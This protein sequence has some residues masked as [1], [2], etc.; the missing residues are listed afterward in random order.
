MISKAK[1]ITFKSE[2]LKV[3]NKKTNFIDSLP[4][5]EDKL[6][7]I[8][9]NIN[10]S[11]DFYKHL[12]NSFNY[13]KKFL[14][15]TNYTS[16]EISALSY[17]GVPPIEINQIGCF[18]SRLIGEFY[19]YDPSASIE[20]DDDFIMANNEQ[21]IKYLENHA[22]YDLNSNYTK[23]QMYDGYRNLLIGMCCF[24]IFTEYK[25]N[26]SVDHIIKFENKD[27]TMVGFDPSAKE[28]NKQDGKFCFEKFIY[29]EDEFKEEFPDIDF[30]EI[31]NASL[32]NDYSWNFY[33]NSKKYVTVYDYYEKEKKK[34]VLYYLKNGRSMKKNDYLKMME[35]RSVFRRLELDDGNTVIDKKVYFE[36][37]INRYRIV[38]DRIISFEKTD[39]KNLPYVFIGRSEKIKDNQNS[40]VR[41]IIVPY[42]KNAIGAQ[43]LINYSA[44][45]LANAMEN[46][47]Q[48][49]WMIP[50][51][52]LPTNDDHLNSWLNPQINSLLVHKSYIGDKPIPKPEPVITKDVSPEIPQTLSSG[53]S[54]IQA[55]LGSFD[56]S[57][58][59]NDNQ[60]SGIAIME[61][62]TQSNA[63]AMPYIATFL[64]GMEYL[65]EI[66]FNLFSIFYSNQRVIPIVDQEGK[67]EFVQINSSPENTIKFD[68]GKIGIKIKIGSSSSI[69]K[70]KSL[71]VM[72][73]LSSKVPAF[74][75]LL[76]EDGLDIVIDNLDVK[77]AD[78]L[79]ARY[80]KFKQQ[81][82]MAQQQ[83]AQN[84]PLMVKNQ[85]EMQKVKLD[86]QKHN[87]HVTLESMDL[88]KETQKMIM[89]A[90]QAQMEQMARLMEQHSKEIIALLDLK[91]EM[92]IHEND[93]SLAKKDMLHRHLGDAIDRHHKIAKSN[94]KPELNNKKEIENDSRKEQDTIQ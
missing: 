54:M 44:S 80:P 20:A 86:E 81:Q 45:K 49:K 9:Q 93:H 62:A 14:L 57:L 70:N 56:S 88:K 6:K 25:N 39:Y 18:V 13:Y 3:K 19:K 73:D 12:I 4:N 8:K 90:N 46:S 65:Y 47:V 48:S 84:N 7:E 29:S 10:F 85:I 40:N 67:K 43:K 87:D 74:G 37:K 66:Y 91:K 35:F 58:G 22:N 23:R 75:Q 34:V 21:I 2:V 15:E 79:K 36:Q 72:T 68:T 94:E 92:V 64:M 30:K 53:L 28:E 38:S 77:G 71:I 50:E 52:A 76:N 1:N 41:E 32:L 16:N 26:T 83:A 31:K 61:G 82:A 42:F 51:E 27:P 17:Q 5:K 89:Q 33:E 63:A 59:I 69:E 24:K 78:L 60:L 11:N 55:T